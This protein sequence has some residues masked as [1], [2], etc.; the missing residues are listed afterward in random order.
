MPTRKRIQTI[1]R[2]VT[3]GGGAGPGPGGTIA[4]GPSYGQSA[5][6]DD[7][8]FNAS[9]GLDLDSV[10]MIGD[11]S[12]SCSVTL[13]ALSMV[14]NASAT[15]ALSIPSAAYVGGVS[16]A[17]TPSFTV[18]IDRQVANE[19]AYLDQSSAGTAFGGAADLI[20]KTTAAVGNN[21]KVAYL[22]WDLTWAPLTGTINSAVIHLWARTSAVLGENGNF[23][24]HTSVAKPFD[25][26]T[27]TWTSDEPI[28]GTNT[29]TISNSLNV[30]LTEKVLTLNA[31]TLA[32]ARGRWLWIRLPGTAALGLNTITVASKENA[33]SGNRPYMELNV[34]L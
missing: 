31:T 2:T 17:I 33:T 32:S 10:S 15:A 1:I 21:A 4:F 23:A 28:T 5:G 26:A 7:S 25:E 22:A 9:V 29:E 20:A 34:T 16:A 30:T 19:D 11:V 13:P 3:N 24:I 18:A 27:A 6:N 14:G 12:A 8:T